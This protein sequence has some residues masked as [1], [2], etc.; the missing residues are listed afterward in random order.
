MNADLPAVLAID[1]GNSKTDLALVAG[2]GELLATVRGP[3]VRSAND[4]G[5]WLEAMAGLIA[6]AQHEAAREGRLAARHIHACV[7]NADLPEEEERLAAALRALGWSESVQ[8]ANDTFAVLRAGLDPAELGEAGHWGAAVTCGAG[9][10]C[11]AVDPSGRTTGYLALGTISGDWGGG[12]GLGQQA[13][14]WGAR[15]EDGRGPETALREAVATH[16]GVRTI[17]DV[18]IGLHLGKIS[19]E[20]LLELAPVLLAVARGGDEVARDIVRRLAGE[21]SV[22]ALTAMGR[23]GLT[24]MATPVVLGGGLLTARDPLL[25]SEVTNRITAA[26]P[27]AAVIVVAVPPVAGAALLGLDYVGAGTDAERRLRAAYAGRGQAMRPSLNLWQFPEDAAGAG[28]DTASR[29]AQRRGPASHGAHLRASGA[30]KR[31]AR[32]GGGQ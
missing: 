8:V 13:L 3:G 4:L 16:F 22:M 6:R 19:D 14:W 29:H 28:P 25:I 32:E 27:Q 15:A 7:A 17:R 24:G 23:L 18:T 26:A 31:S 1:G 11:V 12:Y 5:A 10:N 30:T 9:I 2:D 20:S 21:I